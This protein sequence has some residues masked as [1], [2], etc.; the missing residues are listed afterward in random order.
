MHRL[1]IFFAL[2]IAFVPEV[3]LSA[4]YFAKKSGAA[5]GAAPDWIDDVA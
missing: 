2:F 1:R 3:L 5:I 4:N